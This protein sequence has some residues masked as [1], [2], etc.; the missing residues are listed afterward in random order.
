M[1]IP[2]EMLNA[3]I[4]DVQQAAVRCHLDMTSDEVRAIAT[5]ACY[6]LLMRWDNFLIGIGG[7]IKMARDAVAAASGQV[8]QRQT[9]EALEEAAHQVMAMLA[10]QGYTNGDIVGFFLAL[11]VEMAAGYH[12]ADIKAPEGVA[13]N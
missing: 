13:V 7:A 2:E 4:G 6:G 8:A 11:L 10:L 1:E 12:T 3:A 5:M 9:T